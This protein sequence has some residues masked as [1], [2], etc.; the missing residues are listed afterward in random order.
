[1]REHIEI[2]IIVV[3]LLSILPGIIAA[4]REWLKARRE[5]AARPAVEG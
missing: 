1:V 3:V 2:V 5:A 4:A